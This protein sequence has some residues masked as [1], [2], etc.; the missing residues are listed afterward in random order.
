MRGLVGWILGGRFEDGLWNAGRVVELVV[1][2]WRLENGSGSQLG[3]G[4]V[5]YGIVFRE[6]HAR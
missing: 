3:L 1:I 6:G 5:G 4:D 2:L